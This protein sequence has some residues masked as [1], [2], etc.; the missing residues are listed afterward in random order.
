MATESGSS[1]AVNNN[2]DGDLSKGWIT[3]P[4]AK[5]HGGALACPS[6]RYLPSDGYYY[7]VSGGSIIPLMR[8][9]D[10]LVW[11]TGQ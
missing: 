6:V 11:E 10:L 8:S 3:L 7:T 1:W 4:A 5:A 2:A 9:K